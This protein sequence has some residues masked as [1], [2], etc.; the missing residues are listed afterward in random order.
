MSLEADPLVESSLRVCLR[1][2]LS[3]EVFPSWVFLV[4]LL[5][6]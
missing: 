6:K 1:D 5:I 4:A 2:N 3:L